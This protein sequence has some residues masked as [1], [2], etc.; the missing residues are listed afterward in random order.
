MRSDQVRA[1]TVT[2]KLKLARPLGGG[3]YP[4]LT[5]S[6]SIDDLTDDSATIARLAI[7]MLARITEREK[8]RLAGVQVHNLERADAAQLSLFDSS[9][10]SARLNRALDAVAKRFGDD[11]VTRGLTHAERAA[12]SR[13]IK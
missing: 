13:R 4:L 6:A 12:P 1:R 3:R 7:A 11:A 10:G 8:V 2:L 5:R 9:A